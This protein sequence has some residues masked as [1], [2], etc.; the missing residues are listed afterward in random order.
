MDSP[1]VVAEPEV[2]AETA[3][4]MAKG[5]APETEQKGAQSKGPMAPSQMKVQTSEIEEEPLAPEKDALQPLLK[6]DTA[7]TSSAQL[8]PGSGGW[9]WGLLASVAKAAENFTEAVC[10]SK[11]CSVLLT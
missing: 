8:S 2:K 7:S 5:S 6:A 11:F 10:I 3:E 9:G 1:T 4:R